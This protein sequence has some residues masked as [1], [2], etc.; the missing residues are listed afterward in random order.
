MAITTSMPIRNGV[1]RRIRSNQSFTSR[2]RGGIHWALVPRRVRYPLVLY[3]EAVSPEYLWDWG[4]DG[5]ISTLE[6]HALLDIT[7]VALNPVE[8]ENLDGQLTSLFSGPFADVELD[9]FVDG[10]KV[11]LCRRIGNAGEGPTLDAEGRRVV[12]SGGQFEIWTTQRVTHSPGV[13]LGG[14]LAPSGEVT[15]TST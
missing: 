7:V 3:A 1:V 10:Q 8:A 15:L 9:E 5:H 14:T 12:Q 11:I 6:I 4:A 13:L 2:L